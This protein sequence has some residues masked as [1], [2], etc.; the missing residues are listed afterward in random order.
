MTK[1]LSRLVTISFFETIEGE[2]SIEERKKMWNNVERKIQERFN[3]GVMIKSISI[4]IYDEEG[5]I[6]TK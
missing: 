4:D 6:V 3:Q 5:N 1:E 2:P